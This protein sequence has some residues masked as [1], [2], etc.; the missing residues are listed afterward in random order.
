ML[1]LVAAAPAARGQ[2]RVA[3]LVRDAR[4]QL[5]ALNPDSAVVLLEQ[6]L[7]PGMNATPAE[8]LRAWYL[9]GIAQMGKEPPNL[10]SAQLAFRQALQ[11]DATLRID[12]LDHLAVDVAR[13]FNAER[14]AMAATQAPAAPRAVERL[15]V[16]VEVP[17]D[18][19]LA[20]EGNLLPIT[21]RPSRLAR[22]IVTVSPADAPTVI[23]WGDTLPAGATGALGW[24]L[25]GREGALVAPGRYAL[26][27]SAVDSGGEESV[28]IQRIVTVERMPADT[29]VLPPP[30]AAPAF[31]PDTLRTRG[32]SVTS[33]LVGAGFAAAAAV[34]PTALG[35]PELNG[36]RT[37]DG[38]AYVVAG[39][40]VLAGI[41][42]LLAGERVRY[43]PEN[44]QYNAELRQRDEASRAAIRA[45][46]ALARES[47]PV[48]V[49][50]EGAGP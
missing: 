14:T 28:P 30:L 11:R 13:Q 12:S 19:T 48:R 34:L 2:T 18:T 40:V 22:G 43:A 17:R 9:Y 6:V 47:A 23:V 33:V 50:V 38:T 24:N 15:T 7:A 41:V 25:R 46:N 4:A 3:A 21:P 42:G 16:A 26:H 5:E 27:V 20:A 31:R 32:G 36:G 1:L 29:Q 37:G 35:R 8:Q 10:P 44:V 45:A 49:R 39:T